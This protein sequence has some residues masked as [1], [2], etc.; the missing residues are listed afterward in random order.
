MSLELILPEEFDRLRR[1]ESLLVTPEVER[2][3]RVVSS[4]GSYASFVA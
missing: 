2:E 3:F 1:T 4:F